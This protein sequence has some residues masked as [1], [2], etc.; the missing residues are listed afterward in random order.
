MTDRENRP[1]W[2]R[3]DLISPEREAELRAVLDEWRRLPGWDMFRLCRSDVEW[4]LIN[5]DELPIDYRI[6]SDLGPLSLAVA[7]LRDADLSGLPLEGCN[8]A[9]AQ[10]EGADLSNTRLENANLEYAFLAG[11]RLMGA[12]LRGAWLARTDLREVWLD[13]NTVLTGAHLFTQKDPSPARE[14]ALDVRLAGVRWNETDISSVD[15]IDQFRRL[16]DDLTPLSLRLRAKLR[17]KDSRLAKQVRQWQD[18]IDNAGHQKYISDAIAAY[19]QFARALRNSGLPHIAARAEYRARQLE[20]QVR[21]PLT[22]RWSSRT[23]RRRS[24]RASKTLEREKQRA[25]G[26]PASGQFTSRAWFALVDWLGVTFLRWLN[27]GRYYCARAA[28]FLLDIICGY[29]YKPVRILIVYV[30]TILVFARIYATYAPQPHAPHGW[31][32]IW[33]S[34]IAFHGRGIISGDINPNARILW[35][36]ALEA[37]IGL[38]IEALLVAVII[39]RLFRD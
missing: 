23:I 18:K 37:V 30:V 16:G 13:D 2:Q 5:K 12:D 6:E 10:L 11:A 28:S 31:N 22:I 20:R 24:D 27:S 3:T 1:D 7:N 35:V 36:P 14:Y 25:Q 33:F 17:G 15:D 8:L 39:R 38:G 4:L 29:G 32:T 26:V 34:M 9:L 19:R 21:R